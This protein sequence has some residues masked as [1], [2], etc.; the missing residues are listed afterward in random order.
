MNCGSLFEAVSSN[1]PEELVEVLA[2]GE[3]KLR[4]ERIVSRGHSSPP[5]FWYDSGDAEWVMLLSGSAVLRFERD[6][7]P[8]PLGPGDWIEIPAHCRHRVEATAKDEDTVWL[9]VHWG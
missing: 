7:E 8:T 1:L 2:E 9:A 4:I 6:S 3:G 5:D